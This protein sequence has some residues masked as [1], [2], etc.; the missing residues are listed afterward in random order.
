MEDKFLNFKK[1]FIKAYAFII[2]LG[3]DPYPFVDTWVGVRL[4]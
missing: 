4:T 3:G 1:T 2:A